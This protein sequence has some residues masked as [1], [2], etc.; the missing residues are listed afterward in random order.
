MQNQTLQNNHKIKLLTAKE[1]G[2]YLNLSAFTI[3]K[4]ANERK[5]A[6]VNAGSG[7]KNERKLFLQEDLDDFVIKNRI[8]NLPEALQQKSRSCRPPKNKEVV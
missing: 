4:L 2:E 8:A 1:A 5:I 3:W 7:S 6:F